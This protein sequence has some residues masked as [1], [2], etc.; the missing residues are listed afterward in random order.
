MKNIYDNYNER[1]IKQS[2]NWM[3]KILFKQ[4]EYLLFTLCHLSKA[5]NIDND[6]IIFVGLV[7]Y[8]PHFVIASIN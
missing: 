3:I 7:L 8:Q 5:G 6:F 2:L 4:S 1:R